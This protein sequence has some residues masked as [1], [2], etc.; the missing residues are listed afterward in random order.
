MLLL[1]RLLLVITLC[2]IYQSFSSNNYFDE[3]L[4]LM[5]QMNQLNGFTK[6]V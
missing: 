6:Q 1:V 3:L 5:N 4:S 2:P